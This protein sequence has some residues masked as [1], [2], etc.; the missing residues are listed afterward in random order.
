MNPYW[1]AFAAALK[2]YSTYRQ[3][4]HNK[5]L[6]RQRTNAVAASRQQ[7]ARLL[8]EAL[9]KAKAGREPFTKEA[10]A[11]TRNLKSNRLGELL[12]KIPREEYAVGDPTLT[13]RPSIVKRG[14]TAADA[15]ALRDVE[16]YGRN[17]GDLTAATGA[18]NTTKQQLTSQ[19]TNYAIKEKARRQRVL[20]ALLASKLQGL[21]NTYSKEAD[22]AD[23]AGSLA[24]IYGGGIG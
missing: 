1:L 5:D 13:N 23:K 24:A 12:S 8:E 10:V 16:G 19:D 20:A 3:D 11:K 7:S 21:Q 17:L 6:Q 2:L 9:A 22:I 18:F 15:R 14:S 4:R